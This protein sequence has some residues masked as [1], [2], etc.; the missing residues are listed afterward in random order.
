MWL[1]VWH[2]GIASSSDSSY[3]MLSLQNESGGALKMSREG[4]CHT[5]HQRMYMY[6]GFHLEKL[7]WGG[8]REPGNF[9]PHFSKKWL[10]I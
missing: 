2:L 7:V 10:V 5:V 8:K 1:L 4:A 9:L 3:H 6:P